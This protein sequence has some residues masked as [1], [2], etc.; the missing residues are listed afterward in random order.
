MSIEERKIQL[1]QTMLRLEDE[2]IIDSVEKLIKD[3][4]LKSLE[5]NFKPL[6]QKE[7]DARIDASEADFANGRF[8]SAETLLKKF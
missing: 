8:T 4:Q 7:L 6:T 1:V 3:L 2:Q 5:N